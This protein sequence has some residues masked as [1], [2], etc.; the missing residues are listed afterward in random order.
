MISFAVVGVHLRITA[1]RLYRQ[2]M[3]PAAH[4]V[5]ERV[6]HHAMLLHAGL[7]RKRGTGDAHAK[8]SRTLAR[9]T[10]VQMAFVDHFQRG[11]R[12]G[13]LQAHANDIERRRAH[14]SVW[15][16]GRTVTSR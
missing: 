11:W 10:D 1:S 15:R 6:V 13:L 14:G 4:E 9:V 8:V 2:C 3:D 5:R 12:E 7:S 16:N